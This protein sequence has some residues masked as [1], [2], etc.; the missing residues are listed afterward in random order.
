MTIVRAPSNLFTG[1]LHLPTYLLP[2]LILNV[3][4]TSKPIYPEVLLHQV[5]SMMF[6]VCAIVVFYRASSNQILAISIIAALVLLRI[7]RYADGSG[8]LEALYFIPYGALLLGVGAKMVRDYPVLM[9]N[10][11][12]WIC[13]ISI[14]LSLLQIMGVQWAQ[15]LTNF[16]WY[17]GGSSEAYLFVQKSVL[18]QV[19]GIQTR[20]VGFASANNIVSQYLL[21]FYAYAI[22]W[23]TNRKSQYTPPLKWLFII[24][25][26]CAITGAKLVI[27]GIVLIQIAVWIVTNRQDY[28]Y[29][30][31][32]LFVTIMAY[33][34]Y[35]VL[36]PGLFVMNYNLDLFSFNLMVRLSDLLVR[37]GVPIADEI[38]MFL[39]FYNTGEHIGQKN[40][41]STV[42]HL[43]VGEITGIGSMV[44]YAWILLP[45]IAILV[46]VWFYHLSRL[47]IEMYINR[48]NLSLIMGVATVASTAGGPFL[49]TTYF[50]FFFAIAM[51]P[52]SR[53]LLKP[54]SYVL[55]DPNKARIQYTA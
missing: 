34:L 20:P 3:T 48:K 7:L 10:Q 5:F 40:L 37:Q 35:W 49:L 25:F 33:C 2:L 23:F 17:E 26:A 51:Y 44:R 16:Y 24:S 9:L 30:L 36:F 42:E 28:L 47:P 29:L 12:M 8:L 54:P 55:C 38:F 27:A 39:A 53:I 14:F 11:I 6:I 1:W 41:L 18:P 32:A 21:F 52:F 13:V 45:A 19:Y 50:W 15:S 43:G 22:L 4:F 46:P 31:R